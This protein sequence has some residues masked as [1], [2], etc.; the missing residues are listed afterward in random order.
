VFVFVFVLVLVLETRKLRTPSKYRRKRTWFELRHSCLVMTRF[1]AS[2]EHEHRCAEHEHRCAEHEQNNRCAEHEHRCAEHVILEIS[3]K[4]D[5]VWC[6]I[7]IDMIF[8]VATRM[9]ASRVT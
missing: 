8:V 1:A 3:L 6:L 5:A 2:F 9:A 7:F 4:G